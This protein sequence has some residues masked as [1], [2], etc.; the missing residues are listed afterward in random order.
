M[1]DSAAMTRRVAWSGRVE[2]DP[3]LRGLGRYTADLADGALVARFA[4]ASVA[5]AR[6]LSLNFEAARAMHGVVA[7]LAHADLAS[8]LPKEPAPIDAIKNG[9]GSTTSVPTRP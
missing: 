8:V 2:D 4:R 5:H 6:I 1:R 9:D 7:V 3:L